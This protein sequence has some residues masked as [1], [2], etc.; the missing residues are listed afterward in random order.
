MLAPLSL[1]DCAWL[2]SVCSLSPTDPF[3][4][5]LSPAEVPGGLVPE[6]CINGLLCLLVSSRVQPI[7][8]TY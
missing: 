8:G 1:T 3:S 4:A 2:F 5:L 7:G 6:D